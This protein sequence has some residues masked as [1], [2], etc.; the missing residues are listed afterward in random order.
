MTVD[1]N[2]NGRAPGTV[3]ALVVVR[4]EEVVDL[5]LTGRDGV[6]YESPPQ[7]REQAMA[8]V[9]LLLGC[10]GEPPNGTERWVAP[11][12]GGRRVITLSGREGT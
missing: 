7:S 11:V 10:A 1:T 6:A 2:A 12:A 8:L 3:A 5:A 9:R 4:V